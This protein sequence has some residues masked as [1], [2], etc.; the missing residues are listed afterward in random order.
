[1]IH[2]PHIIKPKVIKTGVKIIDSI[3]DKAFISRNKIR[4][5]NRV[6]TVGDLHTNFKKNVLILE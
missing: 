1:M 2:Q 6:K 5:L 3:K 4:S